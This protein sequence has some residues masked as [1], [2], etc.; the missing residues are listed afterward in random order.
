MKKR[1]LPTIEI[2]QVSIYVVLLTHYFTY[3][4]TTKRFYISVFKYPMFISLAAQMRSR[5]SDV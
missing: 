3:M 4:L 5:P 2:G 1:A